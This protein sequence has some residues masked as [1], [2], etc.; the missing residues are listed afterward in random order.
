MTKTQGRLIIDGAIAGA[1]NMGRDEALLELQSV[2]T[3]RFYRWQNP[4]LSLGYFQNAADVDIAA[5]RQRGCDVVR[6]STGGK[7]I[8]HEHELTYALCAPEVGAL[9][10]GPAAAMQAV[11][12]AFAK[13]LSAQS[14]KN[15]FI[16]QQSALQSDIV[17]SAWCFEDSS[18]LDICL[19]GKKLLGSAARRKNNWIL[20]HGSLVLEV[21][22]ETPEIA[23]LGFEPNISPCVDALAAALGIDFTVGEWT[24]D[25]ISLGDSIATEKYATEAFLHKR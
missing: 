17:G 7:A 24:P 1:V 20:F 5:A 4:T 19:D 16:R 6:R 2:P 9:A 8:L 12:Q 3:L 25:E 22:G 18:P 21:P 10:G 23:A 13:E 14:E 15:V 11:H